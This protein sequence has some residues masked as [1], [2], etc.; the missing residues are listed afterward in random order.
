MLRAADPST[1]ARPLA[2]SNLVFCRTARCQAHTASQ[3]S[4]SRRVILSLGAVALAATPKPAHA[5]FG[6]GGGKSEAEIY[7][8][9]TAKAIQDARAVLAVP[10]DD[11]N[12]DQAILDYKYAS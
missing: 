9:D 10:K 8:E 12:R 7:Q 1:A 4:S 2:R 11:P 5:L 6:F 3:E